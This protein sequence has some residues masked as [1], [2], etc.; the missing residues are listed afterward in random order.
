MHSK[1]YNISSATPRFTS[2]YN[3]SLLNIV[4]TPLVSHVIVGDYH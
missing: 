3:G 2:Y 1:S 4:H